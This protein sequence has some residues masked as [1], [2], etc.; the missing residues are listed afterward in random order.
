MMNVDRKSRFIK[1]NYENEGTQKTIWRVFEKLSDI[2]EI[3]NSDIDNFNKEQIIEALGALDCKTTE[4]LNKEFTYLKR[5]KK[6]S[7]AEG[8]SVFDA[9]SISIYKND[10]IRF[11]NKSAHDNQ[12]IK[13]RQEFYEIL[14]KIYNPQDQI[15]PVLLYEG[16]CGRPIQEHSFEEIKNLKA[17]DCFYEKHTIIARDNDGHARILDDIDVRSMDIIFDAIN[18]TE[19]HRGNGTDK[20]KFAIRPLEDSQF[21]IKK[22]ERKNNVEEIST[23]LIDARIISFKKY[24]GMYW[25]NSKKILFSGMFDRLQ[26]M[27][28]NGYQLTTED[29]REVCKRYLVN[30][31]RWNVLKDKYL[32]FKDI[33]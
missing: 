20:S 3:Y 12:Y 33:K 21:V 9:A 10:L 11:I 13:N 27:E 22:V 23:P 32:A 19:Y 8:Y 25:V 17:T 24:S 30:E 29:Y 16:I 31:N 26:S 14:N 6:W 7:A 4:S 1:E 18:Q 2:E 15:V 28:V 5:Y